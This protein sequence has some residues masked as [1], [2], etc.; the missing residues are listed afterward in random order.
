MPIKGL[1]DTLRLPRLGKLH[2]GIKKVS[3]KGVEYPTATDYFVFGEDARAEAKRVYGTEKPNRLSVIIPIEDDAIF[4]SQFYR[5]YSQTRGCVCRGDGE[6]ASQVQD[7]A[8]HQLVASPA[9]KT[10]RVNVVCP[11]RECPVYAARKCQEVMCLQFMLPDFPG[12]GVWQVDTGSVNSIL[13]IN[14]DIA[15]VRSVIGHIAMVPLTL[16]LEPQEIISPDDGKKKKAYCLHLRASGSLQQLLQAA[17][18]PLARFMLPSPETGAVEVGHVVSVDE[19]GVVDEDIPDADE[20]ATAQP[21]MATIAQHDRIHA[22][23]GRDPDKEAKLNEWCVRK[24]GHGV[25]QLTEGEAAEVVAAMEKRAANE[26][27]K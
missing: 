14:S 26:G 27:M 11:G 3:A 16:S 4:A 23:T 12:L 20:S 8:T 13:N 19:D 15:M 9:A 1:S 2:L 25:T 24:F 5:A 22:L 7:V 18:A 21:I 6:I 10:E 17:K